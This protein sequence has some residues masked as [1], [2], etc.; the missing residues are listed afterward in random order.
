MMRVIIDGVEVAEADANVSVFDWGVQRGFGVFE[1]IRSYG[2]VTF[3]LGPHLERLE[4]SAAAL[5]IAHPP[6]SDLTAWA[7]DVAE[8]GGDCLV[9]IMVTG[10][11]RDELVSS[12]I[13][14]IVLWEPVPEVPERLELLPV[15]APW[16]PAGEASG[17]AGVKW[18]SYAPNMASIDMARRAGFHDAVLLST[19]GQV[20]EGPTYTVAW[21]SEGRL[22]TPSL[23]A[24]I[25]A[26]ITREVLLECAEL[27]GIPV[28]E[29]HFPLERMIEADEAVALSTV[30]E[31]TLVGRIGEHEIPIG[32]VSEKLA[33]A[34]RQ[35]VSD[36]VAEAE[37]ARDR[38]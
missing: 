23:Q 29:G 3:R 16:H 34:F 25:L 15:A 35:L 14:T 36:E 10:G 24:G 19:D 37:R 13:R 26:S 11:S 22:E 2:G 5:H 28:K 30:K 21:V 1:V 6:A 20:L 4:R 33:G 12:P 17:F 32:P 8:D 38:S 9:R 18:L 31:V 27:L 7:K